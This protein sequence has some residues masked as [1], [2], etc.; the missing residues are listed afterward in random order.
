MP[1]K[2]DRPAVSRLRAKP[3]AYVVYDSELSGF[4]VRVAPGGS[5][6]WIAEYRPNGGGRRSHTKRVTLGSTALL[7]PTQARKE[8]RTLLASASLGKDP[9]AVKA[10]QR[11]AL[12]VSELSERFMEE[13]VK[14]T[15]KPRTAQ[16][17][18]MYFRV[19]IL[20]EV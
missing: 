16:L 18:A 6:S 14:P 7:S 2:L 15:R 3:S 8:A 5:K 1:V 10:A 9:A 12:T 4:G 20:P 19:H 17:Y 13:E 11:V